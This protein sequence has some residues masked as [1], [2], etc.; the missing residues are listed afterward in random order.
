MLYT[1]GSYHMEIHCLEKKFEHLSVCHY[2]AIKKVSWRKLACLEVVPYFLARYARFLDSYYGLC[3][4]V[5]FIYRK[6]FSPLK[7]VQWAAQK[8]VAPLKSIVILFPLGGSLRCYETVYGS[9]D[10]S[11]SCYYSVCH[12]SQFS[13]EHLLRFWNSSRRSHFKKTIVSWSGRLYS[14]FA[15]GGR[16]SYFVIIA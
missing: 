8:K 2:L 7:F 10:P 12:S 11:P 1:F 15:H 6:S 9:Y 3:K 5:K 13:V 14:I 16:V 4:L